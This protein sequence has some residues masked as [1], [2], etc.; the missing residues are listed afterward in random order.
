MKKAL[1]IA[2]VSVASVLGLV[3]AANSFT[4]VEEGFT[5]VE[6]C[7]GE[8][9]GHKGAGFHLV[10]P[11]CSFDE[12]ETRNNKDSFDNMLLPT[13]DRFNST[14]DITVT[15]NIDE[16]MTPKIKADYG[17]MRTFV[18]RALSVHLVNIV[19]DEGRKIKDSRGLADSSNITAM[20]QSTKAR[21][22]AALTGTGIQLNEVLVQNIKF[23]DRIAAQILATQQRFQQEEAEKSKERIEESKAA[24]VVAAERGRTESLKLNADAVAYKIQQETEANARRIREMAE[25]ERFQMEQIAAGNKELQASLTPQI[26][27]LKELEV[28]MKE[29]GTGWKGSFADNMTIVVGE[30]KTPNV[31]VLFKELK[32]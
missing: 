31:P 20:Q 7:F 32:K 27:K 3:V 24:Q 16:A 15:Y 12:Y 13:Q 2:A 25:A 23:D 1:S 22:Q 6:M 9:Q 11:W 8:V 14:V 28:Q 17:S 26:I 4:V 18:D 29:A 19:K 21:L 10:K 5:K 30:G